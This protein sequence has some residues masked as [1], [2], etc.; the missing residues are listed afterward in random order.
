MTQRTVL[1]LTTLALGTAWCASALGATSPISACDGADL[2]SLEV[3]VSELSPSVVGHIA[4][5]PDN[6]ES[7]DASPVQVQSTLPMLYL[8]PRVAAILE[9][10]FDAVA[11]ET[12]ASDSDGPDDSPLSPVA[13]DASQSDSSVISD[14]ASDFEDAEPASSYQRQMFRTDI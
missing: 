14:I 11:I 9:T 2:Q 10:V 1:L 4:A 12:P 8:T 6:A 7:V 3:P 13:G 5:E